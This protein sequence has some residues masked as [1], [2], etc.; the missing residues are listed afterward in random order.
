M[1]LS[2]AGATIGSA[3]IGGFFGALGQS[4]ANRA[5]MRMMREQMRFQERMSNTAVQRRMSDLE[6]AGI[7]PILAG[8]FDASTPPGA[9]AVMG[10]VGSAAVQGA[11]GAGGTAA[12][13]AKLPYEVDMIRVQTELTR[14]KEN[15][16]GLMGDMA[17]HLRDFDWQAMGERFRADVELA[18][19][20]AGAL[21]SRGIATLEEIGAAI[22]QG[23]G[24]SWL[25]L[26]DYIDSAS[27]WISENGFKFRTPDEYQRR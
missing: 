15:V 7:N 25:G 10:D 17:A 5:N 20:A 23:L 6:A 16:T 14:N 1:P 21:V 18:I 11:A 13:L 3:L 19:A 24:D 26:T 22:K 9:M 27:R 2:Q 12:M 8:S 4:R